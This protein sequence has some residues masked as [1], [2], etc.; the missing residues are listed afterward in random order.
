MLDELELHGPHDFRHTLS[1]WLEEA[2]IPA[3]V[4]DEIMG[5]QSGQTS[6]RTPRDSGSRIGTR[7]RHTTPEMAARVVAAIEERLTIMLK[8]AEEITSSSFP[9]KKS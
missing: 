2:G 5:H 9:L 4:I 8:G 6:R 7:Y 1:T 3:R